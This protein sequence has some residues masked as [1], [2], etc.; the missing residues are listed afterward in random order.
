MGK[1]QI[2]FNRL[3]VLSKKDATSY[4][5]EMMSH[6]FSEEEGWGYSD[7]QR[8]ENTVYACLAEHIVNGLWYNDPDILFQELQRVTKMP[9]VLRGKTVRVPSEFTRRFT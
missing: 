2:V 3:K 7:V 4:S 8:V 9:N 5:T 6:P 1:Y